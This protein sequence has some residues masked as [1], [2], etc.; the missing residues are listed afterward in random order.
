M[1]EIMKLQ[2]LVAEDSSDDIELI[3]LALDGDNV[4]GGFAFVRD[5]QE[6]IDY[7]EGEGSFADRSAYPFPDLVVLDLKMPQVNGLEV[8]RWVRKHAYWGQL[9]V[10]MLSGSSLAADI[11]EAYRL[12]ANSYFIKPMRV[13]ALADLLRALVRY[14]SLS[15]RPALRG[16]YR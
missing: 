7:L 1:R 6:A 2:I 16:S 15:Q 8:L 12:G 3:K 5:G 11:E 10:V 9:P 14:W 4:L 13:D